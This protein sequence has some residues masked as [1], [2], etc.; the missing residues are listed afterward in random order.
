MSEMNQEK[1]TK[2]SGRLSGIR[3][4][5]PFFV[6]LGLLTVVSF[7]IPLRPTVSY[8]EKRELAKFP[9]FSWSALVSGDYFDD[10]TTWFSDTFPGR[11]KWVNVSDQ[12]KSLYGYSEIT[13]E[14]SLE[15]V[16][17]EIPVA[18]EIPAPTQ[19]EP[20]VEQETAV[21]ETEGQET[22]AP[23]QTEPEETQSAQWGGVDAGEN[24]TVSQGD[25]VIAQ[26]MDGLGIK[27]DHGGSFL[28]GVK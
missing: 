3:L 28:E 16:G 7:I 15:A 26:G 22:T 23:A 18:D 5:I 9:E 11:Q 8:E 14:G 10:I 21:E 2:G 17:D 13:I 24:G 27:I 4:V 25:F 20:P 12:M 6:V 19:P 1:H